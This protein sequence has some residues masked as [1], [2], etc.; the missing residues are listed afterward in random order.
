MLDALTEIMAM[1]FTEG[2]Q[3]NLSNIRKSGEDLMLKSVNVGYEDCP[4][5]TDY[6]I[7]DIGKRP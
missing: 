6:S 5:A 2:N 3:I 1:Q 4:V 7:Y